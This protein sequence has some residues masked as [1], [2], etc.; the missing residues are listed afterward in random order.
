MA[1][2]GGRFG[3]EEACPFEHV[4]F[5]ARLDLSLGHQIHETPLIDTPVAF[6]LLES[7][8]HGVGRRKQGLMH[9]LNA[10]HFS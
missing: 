2:V 1:E 9:V 10:R 8:K 5:E 4:W 7:L 3:A 6:F